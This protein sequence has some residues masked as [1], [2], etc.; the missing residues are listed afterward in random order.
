M[1]VLEVLCAAILAVGIGGEKKWG[2]FACQQL[3]DI[4]RAATA[5]NLEPEL[6]IALIHHESRFR[7]HAV[8]RAN[9]CGLMQ[10][11]PRFTGN[12]K[13]GVNRGT[14]VPKLSCKDLKDPVT[15]I[16]YGTMTLRYWIQKYA[17]G[18]KRVGLCGY[19]AGFRCKG[20]TPHVKGMSYSRSVLRTFQKLKRKVKKLT[21]D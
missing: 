20:K 15:N 10:V 3:P 11:M 17:R 5:N 21:T 8:S 2:E 16:K 14:G 1:P 19:N 6:I 18:K 9:A 4:S 12:G 7:P 13:G